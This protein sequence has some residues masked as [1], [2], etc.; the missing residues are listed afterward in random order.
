MSNQRGNAAALA[1]WR[2]GKTPEEL[3][4]ISAKG[5]K[6]RREKRIAGLTL[7][8][9]QNGVT[10]DRVI[11]VSMS[12][13]DHGAYV[14]GSSRTI[15]LEGCPHQIDDVQQAIIRLLPQLRTV[16]AGKVSTKTAQAVAW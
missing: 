5:A 11:Y 9:A 2:A 13:R 10:P 7:R 14:P 4:A 1:K 15:S 12:I 16:L 6:V 8:A 3:K